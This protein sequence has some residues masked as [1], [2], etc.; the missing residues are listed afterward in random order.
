MGIADTVFLVLFKQFAVTAVKTGRKIK[1]VKFSPEGLICF[2]VPDFLQSLL[3]DIA[4]GTVGDLPADVVHIG[5]A[6]V[7][8][9]HAGSNLPIRTDKG[10]ALL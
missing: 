9:R 7:Q 1:F 8:Q 5:I 10:H 3:P 6:V 2:A 4:E